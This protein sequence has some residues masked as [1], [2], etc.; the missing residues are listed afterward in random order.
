MPEILGT[1]KPPRLASAPGSPA[2][3]QLYYNTGTNLLMWWNGTAWVS[4][5]GQTVLISEQILGA[6]AAT[7]TFSSI[8]ATYH[9]LK[10][11]IAKAN[12]DQSGTQTLYMRFNSDSGSSSY[13]NNQ[14]GFRSEIP[15]G[16]LPGTAMPSTYTMTGMVEIPYYAVASAFVMANIATIARINNIGNTGDISPIQYPTYWQGSATPLNRIDLLTLTG[17]VNAGAR[18]ALYGIT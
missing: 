6:A 17:S 11:Y 9:A 16:S 12:S 15:V 5:S 2:L 8:P 7:I 18:F 1:L 4:A 14:Q 3:G 13:A 10:L